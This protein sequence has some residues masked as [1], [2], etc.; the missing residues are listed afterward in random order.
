MVRVS[1]RAPCQ[2]GD[3]GRR[4][5]RLRYA[6]QNLQGTNYGYL[7]LASHAEAQL[8]LRWREIR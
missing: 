6:C 5:F 1:E 2:A 8:K 4:F 3:Q 7:Y